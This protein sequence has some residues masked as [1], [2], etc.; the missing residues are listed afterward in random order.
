[1]IAFD[2]TSVPDRITWPVAPSAYTTINGLKHG[3]I[4]ARE[5]SEN[6][7]PGVIV[8]C[9]VANGVQVAMMAMAFRDAGDERDFHLFDSFQGIPLAGRHDADQPGIGLPSHDVFAPIEERLVSSGV[10]S[11]SRPDVGRNLNRW[12]PDQ[13]Y[14]FH[15][16]WF[17]H[18]LPA[19]YDFPA[20][21]LLRLDGDLYESTRV[22]LEHLYPRVVDRG[23]VVIDD[24]GL[25]GCRKAVDEYLEIHDLS[26]RIQIQD[27]GYPIACWIK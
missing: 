23:L 15:E 27:V 22:C 21:A 18:I 25:P 20:I 17:Q 24:Y 3:Y 14:H 9:G 5:V 11:C 12:C 8:E 10:S 13:R 7:I 16:G 6:K 2:F 26:P 19:L 1:M 4:C